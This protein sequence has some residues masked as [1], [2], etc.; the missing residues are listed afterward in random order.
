MAN[1]ATVAQLRLRAQRH[2]QM[3]NSNF[4]K[5]DEWLTLLNLGGSELWDLLVATN[6]D[7]CTATTTLGPGTNTPFIT[8]QTL[9]TLPGDVLRMLQVDNIIG[10]GPNDKWPMKRIPPGERFRGWPGQW[11]VGYRQFGSSIEF[12]PS[13]PPQGTVELRY[14]PQW[15]LFVNETDFVP[16]LIPVGWEEYIPLW[17]AV[18][19]MTKQRVD[20]SGP[21]G[22]LEMMKSR[23]QS[24]AQDRDVNAPA[25][26]ADTSY[27][28]GPRF[29]FLPPNRG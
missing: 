7:W 11:S 5:P 23:I 13:T 15:T 4:V 18:R 10:P 14:V 24:M 19:A 17:A 8:N 29:P 12:L 9:Y 28:F 3:E 16:S 25:R 21:A 27:R 22:L 1:T 2:A 26:V 20:P 6:E